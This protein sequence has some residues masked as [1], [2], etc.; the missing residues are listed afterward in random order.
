MKSM[1][2]LAAALIAALGLAACAE[3]APLRVASDGAQ[4]QREKPRDA[5]ARR[6][7]ERHED[8]YALR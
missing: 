6:A 5:D 1:L 3:A 4:I 7:R 2:T 8:T